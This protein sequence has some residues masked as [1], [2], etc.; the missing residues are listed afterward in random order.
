MIKFKIKHILYLKT[1]DKLRKSWEEQ[2]KSLK[3]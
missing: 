2:L 3:K 1:V